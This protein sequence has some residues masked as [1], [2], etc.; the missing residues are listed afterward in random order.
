MMFEEFLADIPPLVF[1]GVAVVGLVLAGLF[2]FLFLRARNRTD[3]PPGGAI[4]LV[5]LILCLVLLV[6]A[7]MTLMLMSQR[8]GGA[9]AATGTWRG[10][11]TCGQGTTGVEVTLQQSAGEGLEGTFAFFPTESNPG[12]ARGCFRVTTPT[13]GADGSL[14]TR[15]GEWVR[16]PSGY[17][18]VDLSGRL[19]GGDSW[20]GQVIGGAQCTGFELRRVATPQEGCTP[21]ADTTA[22]PVVDQT[23]W[24]IGSWT[25]SGNCARAMTFNADR[26]LTTSQGQPGT[27]T[28]SG[29]LGTL[30][31]TITAAGTTARATIISQSPT[32]ARLIP[33][34]GS[35]ALELT[36]CASSG[37]P[38]RAPS[39]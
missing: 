1:A 38:D 27:W 6:A 24:L 33:T 39:L 25:S 3:G 21:T 10:T 4:H 20:S 13:D 37:T 36:R 23:A 22:P 17:V 30:N 9:M 35:A 7:P 32:S 28:A 2:L 34:D 19:S 16:Q 12:V 14:Q 29:A 15:A 11:Y 8:S 31:L 18:S 26:T 5:F